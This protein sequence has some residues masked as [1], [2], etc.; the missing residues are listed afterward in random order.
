[1][2]GVEVLE[3]A[4][5]RKHQLGPS[6][7][8]TPLKRLCSSHMTSN[9]FQNSTA[10]DLT[11][12][13]DQISSNFPVIETVVDV[14]PQGPEHEDGD[15]AD[16]AWMELLVFPPVAATE[17]SASPDDY[18]DIDDIDDI[19][20]DDW[21]QL[22]PKTPR[23]PPSTD[24]R[25]VEGS[26]RDCNSFDPALQFSPATTTP[27]SKTSAP[28]PEEELLD[29]DVDWDE[30]LS[31][32]DKAGPKSHTSSLGTLDDRSAT[33]PSPIQRP[34][35]RPPVP[36]KL[37]DRPVVP[38]LSSSVV[39]RVCFRIGELLSLNAVS[40]RS[41][42]RTIFEL[43]AR[44]TYS[45]RESLSRTQHFQFMD[46]FTDRQPFPA[47]ILKNWKPESVLD[48]RAQVFLTPGQKL[49]CRVVCTMKRSELSG[50]GWV[51]EVMSIEQTAWEEISWVRQMI[52]RDDT[53][54]NSHESAS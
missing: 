10:T 27:V 6:P 37:N 38:G 44:V 9:A 29:E 5:T 16:D 54:A 12:N 23:S 43:F 45:T 20:D 34:F 39:L 25:N 2:E 32:L 14:Q 30:V 35:V 4:G 21:A 19:D 33:E 50:V 47:G 24:V 26:S 31:I 36:A 22:L 11:Q 42:Q 53:G 1:M 8:E 7:E 41:G 46:L 13:I 17:R 52:T 48:Q 40:Q 15:T 3:P 28:S 18:D 49:L 51:L